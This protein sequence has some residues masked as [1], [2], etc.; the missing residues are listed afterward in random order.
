MRHHPTILR[1][2]L[3]GAIVALVVAAC[4]SATKVE[5]TWRAPPVAGAQP[6]SNVVTLFTSEEPDVSVRRNAEDQL[7]RQLISRGLRATPSYMI[8]GERD[9]TDL[10]AARAQLRSMGYDGVVTMRIVDREQ[11]LDYAPSGYW[12]GTWGY[13]YYSGGYAFLETTYRVETVAYSLANDQ[14]VWSALVRT[15]DPEDTGDLIE[16]TSEAVAGELLEPDAG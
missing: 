12:G 6:M 5:K 8:L 7:A 2:S 4:G 1:R 10:P 15:T 13:P 16:D 9:I 14:I 11:E 3:V